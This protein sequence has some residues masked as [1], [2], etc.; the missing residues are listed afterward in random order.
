MMRYMSLSL[1]VKERALVI[2]F[3]LAGIAPIAAWRD[4]EFSRQWVERGYGG[5]MQYL[6]NPQRD[7]PRTILPSA[8]S[9]ICV[10][11]IY[12]AP[13]PYSTEFGSR[14]SG[15]GS[16]GQGQRTTDDGP[17]AWISRYAW[18]RDYHQTMRDKLEELRA[19]IETLSPGGETRVYVDTG[20]VIERA[21]ARLSG[22]GW[23]G[24]NTCL[25]NQQKGS[26]FFLGVVLTS[27]ALEP[28]LPAPD[29]CG[30]CTRCIEACPTDALV[31]PYVMNASRCIAYLNIE[32]K[33]SIPEEFRP[34]VG[35]NVFGCDICQDVCPWN[36]RQSSVVS[37][38]S[39]SAAK[40][41]P[42]LYS[43]QHFSRAAQ[44]T[45]AS[46]FQPL[47]IELRSDT[48]NLG[49]RTVD[50]GQ[51]T[52]DRVSNFEFRFS[53]FNPPLEALAFMTEAD[54]KRTFRDS[55]VRRVKYRGWLR[56]LC[57]AMGNSGDARFVPRLREL[58]A[59]PEPI[60]REH[61]AWA[62]RRLGELSSTDAP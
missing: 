3:D 49:Q 35:A 19:A 2:G 20:P 13:L 33:G 23:T 6:Q 56:N 21:F 45:K 5:E 62:L 8:Q 36:G 11:Q 60:V 15:V 50:H 38:Q 55:P 30:S 22:I 1:A 9:V 24:K 12:N 59:H 10:G 31:E 29:R 58:A 42:E 14:E 16:R 43:G 4:L 32:L 39:E 52:N 7:D 28:D 27:L 53:L 18:G 26:W 54:F 51:L 34:A 17:R 46:E 57:V 37:R 61:A 25:I 40:S 41:S 48:N 44:T 47:Q